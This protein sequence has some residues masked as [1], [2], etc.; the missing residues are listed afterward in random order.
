MWQNPIGRLPPQSL[1]FLTFG[2]CMTA[3]VQRPL[4]TRDYVL[5]LVVLLGSYL[6]FISLM[7]FMALYAAERFQ[8]NDT[9]AGFA[10][11]SFVIGA[12]LIRLVIG[13]Y[14]DFIGRKR[15]LLI[16]LSVYVLSSLLYP[17]I[18][19]YGLL[20]VLRI[21]QGTMFGIISTA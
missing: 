7:T 20:I 1:S 10:S 17:F 13:K 6:V 16:A 8:A 3:T 4:F 12:G 21:V 15:T 2:V 19:F 9:A 18:D 11:S 5:G 14:L